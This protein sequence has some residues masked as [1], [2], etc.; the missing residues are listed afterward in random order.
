MQKT[1]G[2]ISLV[3]GAA[4]I[5]WGYNMS[6]SLDGQASNLLHGSPGVKPMVCYIVGAVLALLGIG[7][8]VRK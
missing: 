1:S 2:L 8:I 3:V 4:L 7:Q 6:H 5:Y